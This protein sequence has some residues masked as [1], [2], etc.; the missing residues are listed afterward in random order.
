MSYLNLPAVVTTVSVPVPALHFT[1]HREGNGCFCF[2]GVENNSE[3][4][5][6]AVSQGR[7]RSVGCAH[8][9]AAET[10]AAQRCLRSPACS[11]ALGHAGFCDN[12]KSASAAVRHNSLAGLAAAAEQASIGTPGSTEDHQPDHFHSENSEYTNSFDISLVGVRSYLTVS[13][14]T[15]CLG[16][17]NLMLLQT[18]ATCM[19]LHKCGWSAQTDMQTCYRS[20]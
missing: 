20:I 2:Q 3:A 11:K 1:P 15:V 7:G 19:T 13:A 8:L 10:I 4:A 14:L 17:F 12:G 6:Y 9:T 5:L 18:A 16:N